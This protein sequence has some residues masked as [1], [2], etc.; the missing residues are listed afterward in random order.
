MYK[1]EETIKKYH[2]AGIVFIDTDLADKDKE[3]RHPVIRIND[4]YYI[5][6]QMDEQD[7]FLYA[8]SIHCSNCKKYINLTLD[9]R[10]RCSVKELSDFINNFDK[11][12]DEIDRKIQ[13]LELISKLED[14][15]D[16]ISKNYR[17]LD[18][19]SIKTDYD[20]S[21]KLAKLKDTLD[22]IYSEIEA[23]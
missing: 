7:N 17:W 18:L 5:T 10:C 23:K 16:A 19:A 3:Y 8:L 14:E 12:K 6:S 21:E 22:Y 15:L 9:Y 20:N 4:D 13:K 1:F 11:Y 2:D